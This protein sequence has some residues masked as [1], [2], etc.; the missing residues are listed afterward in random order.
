MDIKI[1]ED[2]TG[3]MMFPEKSLDKMSSKNMD[4]VKLFDNKI[5]LR[6]SNIEDFLEVT[7]YL[8][9][10]RGQERAIGCYIVGRDKYTDRIFGNFKKDANSA[11]KNIGFEHHYDSTENVVFDHM[12]KFDMDGQS[13]KDIDLIVEAKN[14]G[15]HANYKG[16]DVGE[17]AVFCR[18]IL[19][20]ISSVDIVISTVESNLGNVNITRSKIHGE[21]LSPTVQGKQILD[22]Q[23]RKAE[24]MRTEEQRLVEE[25]RKLE[26]EKVKQ[27]EREVVDLN[28]EKGTALVKE[29]L[30]IKRKAGY[31]DHE[32]DSYLTI[33]NDVINGKLTY[34]PSG[35]IGDNENEILEEDGR[36]K[37]E[38]KIKQGEIGNDKIKEGT[39]IV[40]DALVSKRK[41]GYSD[42]EINSDN[43]IKN[44]GIVVKNYIDPDENKK[45]YKYGD[46]D[47]SDDI[48]HD[49]YDRLFPI[50]VIATILIIIWLLASLIFYRQ[51]CVPNYRS[52]ICTYANIAVNILGRK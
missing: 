10:R 50:V 45:Y 17:I 12:E 27:K 37:R 7:C 23:I 38:E 3:L 46:D 30:D 35:E 13:H 9:V 24:Q 26:E 1:F 51:D 43:R 25:N 18:Q 11:L 21:L 52:N 14:S 28:I 31:S 32:I 47:K 36:H 48:K 6:I 20:R 29:G 19:K 8:L 39:F 49:T 16:G 44:S 15:E 41:D 5:D 34:F 4:I 2:Q 33:V 42:S 22:R 40:K